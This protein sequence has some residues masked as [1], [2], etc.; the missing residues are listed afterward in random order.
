ATTGAPKGVPTSTAT[1]SSSRARPPG[2]GVGASPSRSGRTPSGA[3]G[4]VRGGGG[5]GLAT[6]GEVLSSLAVGEPAAFVE[7][8][9]AAGAGVGDEVAEAQ[10]LVVHGAGESFVDGGGGQ[11]EVVH[12]DA[13]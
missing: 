11:L 3:R 12:R 7:V 4:G 8:V 1:T 13:H 5:R 6:G 9:E 2:R 10:R